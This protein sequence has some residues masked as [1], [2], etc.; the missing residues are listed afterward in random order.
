MNLFNEIYM[1]V[2]RRLLVHNAASKTNVEFCVPIQ[3]AR[4]IVT[5]N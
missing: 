5:V 1:T 4:Q 3:L 2:R